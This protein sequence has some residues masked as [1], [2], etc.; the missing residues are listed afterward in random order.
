MVSLANTA[1]SFTCTITYLNTP[2]YTAFSVT[3][4]HEDR[5]GRQ[6]EEEP[7][8]CPPGSG[9]ENKTHTVV[10]RITPKLPSASAT[11]TYYCLVRWGPTLKLG[12]GTFILVRGEV[13]P[14]AVPAP[15]ELRQS[16]GMGSEEG[17]FA[18]SFIFGGPLAMQA[19]QMRPAH[20]CLHAH[21]H[22]L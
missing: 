21:V 5:E 20:V 19:C 11:G 3:Y 17:V 15:A 4:M 7:V 14:R 12:E 22:S 6:S 2:E 16:L 1:V 9:T 10:C 18:S 8:P 13:A